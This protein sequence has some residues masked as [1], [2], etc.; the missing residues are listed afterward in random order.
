MMPPSR[1]CRPGTGKTSSPAWR[2]QPERQFAVRLAPLGLRRCARLTAALVVAGATVGAALAQAPSV[3]TVYAV[4]KPIAE[5]ADYVGRID[6]IDRVEIRARVQGY[7]ERVLFK[8][9]DFVKPGDALYQIEKGPFQAAVEQAQAALDKSQAEK[10]FTA[11][12]LKRQETLL[13]QNATSADARDQALAADR[14]AAATILA[15]QAS[16]DIAKIN[17]GYTD[18]VAP[19][20]GKISRTNITIGNVVGPDSGPLTLIVSQNPMYVT[21]PVSQ[22]ELLRVKMGDHQVDAKDIKVKIRFA[23]GTLYNQEGFI[24]FVDVSVN[25]A[26]DTVLVRAT[27]ANPAGVLID[28]Q[29]VSVTLESGKPQERVVV[30]QSALIADQQGIYVFVVEDGKAEVRRVT[31]GAEDG[32]NIVI[33]RGLQGGEQIIVQGIQSVRPGQPV[34]ASP[35]TSSLNRS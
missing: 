6:A 4:R 26:T 29:L 23:N 10:I 3:G 1:S 20:S 5:T 15:N 21:F 16:L 13:A 8:E 27:M 7:L 28:G 14:E 25:R 12:Q 11:V 30:P 34:Q 9:G 17:L 22:R 2:S 19:I 35:L 33:E 18:I 24:N 32:P 31:V